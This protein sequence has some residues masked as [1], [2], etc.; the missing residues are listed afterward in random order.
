MNMPFADRFQ[1]VFPALESKKSEFHLY[2]YTTV[3]EE[4]LWQFCVSKMWRKKDSS[5]LA[6]HEVVN[7]VL[8]ISPAAYMTYTQIEEQRTSNW[9]TDLNQEELQTLLSPHKKEPT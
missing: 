7:D 4:D 5:T 3:T 1:Q 9:F 8:S 6:L 2:G